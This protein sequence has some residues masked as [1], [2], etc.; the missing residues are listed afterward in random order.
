VLQYELK[1]RYNLCTYCLHRQIA[2]VRKST[3]VLHNKKT[4]RLKR[5]KSDSCYICQGIMSDLDSTIKKICGA[6]EAEEYEFDSFILGASLPSGMFERE[7]SIRA[8]FKVRGRKNIRKQFIDEL[9]RRLEKITEKRV[10]YITPD[11]AIHIVIANEDTDDTN[12]SNDYNNILRQT[13]LLKASPIFLSGRYVKTARGLPQKKDNCQTCLGR[14]CSLC[15]YMGASPFDSV[16]AII[17]RRVIEITRGD[18]TRFS[19][20]GG[21]DKDSLVL[22][23]G[24]PFVVRVS[25]PKVRWLK[26]DLIIED[27]GLCV[28]IKQQTPKHSFQL[29][30]RF[31][32]KTKITIHTEGELSYEKLATLT[33]AL[34][35]SEVS[36][37]AKSKILKKKIYS[38]QVEQ[39]DEKRFILTV[40][41]DGGLFIKQF[42][43]GQQYS[44]PNISKITGIKCE[45]V[46]FDV[47]EVNAQ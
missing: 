2:Q 30:S 47:L 29:P 24:R 3:G 4:K 18:T 44:E 5:A 11:I 28:V 6:I 21:E 19:W 27:N 26:K 20:L 17:S 39:I 40:T 22:G 23:K 14:G 13:V 10:Q 12:D 31:T 36:F 16:E 15:G 25:N 7:D 42:V 34:E 33:S 45:C 35:N 46:A 9:R 43:G 41:A 32:T 38:V 1:K 8:R 37:R